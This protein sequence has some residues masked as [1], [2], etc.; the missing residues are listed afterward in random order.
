MSDPANSIDHP[1]PMD[2]AARSKLSPTAL[3][4]AL[5][6]GEQWALDQRETLALIGLLA[7][8]QAESDRTLTPDQFYRAG[9][10]M[11]VYRA[12]NEIFADE[13]AQEWPVLENSAPLFEG[14]SACAFMAHGGTDAMVLVVLYLRAI[15]QGL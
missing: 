13:M 8:P 1:L 9:L 3:K 2:E 10:L 4:V 12:L 5:R 14:S 15:Q 11:Q 7:I 6:I